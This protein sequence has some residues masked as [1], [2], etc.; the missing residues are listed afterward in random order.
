MPPSQI[1]RI[2]SCPSLP[3][4]HAVALKVLEL[5]RDPQVSI[6]RIAA[7]VQNDPALTT[8][9]LR[10]VN[11]SVYGLTT[12]CPNISRAMSLLGLNTVKS[13]VLSFSLVDMAKGMSD[14]GHL[15]LVA[16]WRRAVYGAAAARVIALGTRACDPEEAFTGALLQ[17]IGMLAAF[18]SLR[19]EYASIIGA[20]GEDHDLT[21]A[22]ERRALGADHAW[23]G[24]QLAERWKLSQQL[25]HCITHHHDA[26]SCPP[27][28]QTIVR[29]VALGGLAT[30]ALTLAHP[31]D[32]LN[33]YF[34]CARNWFSL[35]SLNAR[36]LVES[37]AASATDL[38]K[39]L[40]LQTGDKPDVGAILA[41]AHEQMVVTQ[42]ALA[43][44]SAELKRSNEE[45]AKRATI[46][47]LT[48]AYNR[49]HFDREVHEIVARCRA[50]NQ[51]VTVI[52]LDADK[53]KSVNDQHGHQAGDAVL[54]EIVR[55]LRETA[56]RFGTLCRFGGE[57][58]VLV[59]PNV[60]LDKGRKVGD[61]LR[62]SIER[63]PFDLARYD[64]PGIVLNRTIS[65]GVAASEP[66]TP[67]HEWTPEQLT[68]HAD[69][70]VYA[71]KQ[72]GRNCVRFVNTDG[73]TPDSAPATPAGCI[74]A[75]TGCVRVLIVDDDPFSVRILEKV[76]G[77]RPEF[78]ITVASGEAEALHA[79]SQALSVHESFDLVL[80]D[81]YLGDARGTAVIRA[82]QNLN[83][84]RAA[85][86]VLVSGRTTPG[87]EEIARAAGAR[88]YLD[89]LDFSVSASGVLDR[90]LELVRVPLKAA[91]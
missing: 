14:G 33:A 90:L 60:N 5:T 13:I 56:E 16:Y 10:T 79:A 81:H 55:R 86:F 54:I 18:T 36:Q 64:M 21:L 4:L 78:A 59:L 26:D 61:L 82:L 24:G 25:V 20:A 50:A 70:A 44:E 46:D 57:E 43:Q 77:A 1:D 84:T 41:E 58:F 48:G 67:S 9:V 73:S 23:I 7:A 63:A 53:F 62:Q 88:L 2:L 11:S 22:V 66:G 42:A 31:K 83:S 17:D 45:L 74:P 29:V 49:A 65:V 76:L 39:A 52:F 68:H 69:E 27:S 12:P 38:S 80:M 85:A 89:K 8:K 51:P 6:A 28:H 34:A 91:A 15:D 72:A 3:T 30:G 75:P 37:A 71:A 40:D 19:R 35:D 87:I 32:K 47:G